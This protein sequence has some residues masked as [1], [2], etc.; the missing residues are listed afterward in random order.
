MRTNTIT[1]SLI[2]LFIAMQLSANTRF[3]LGGSSTEC[4][5]S[6]VINGLLTIDQTVWVANGKLL[7]KTN[8]LGESWIR[9]NR[10]DVRNLE[11]G[12]IP[13]LKARNGE[14]W[15]SVVFDTTFAGDDILAGGG[16][17]YTDDWGETW[18]YIP[19]P[20]DSDDET[21]YEPVK[22]PVQNTTWDLALTD[23][24]V[25]IASWGGGIRRSLDKGETWEVITA[26]GQPLSPTTNFTHMGFA[27]MFDEEAVWAG[28][29]SGIYRTTDGGR[30]WTNYNHRDEGISGN[31]VRALDVQFI[32][33]KK[34]I[35]ASTAETDGSD[36]TEFRGIAK[37]EDN[38]D[39]WIV[40]LE[41]EFAHE[42]GFEDNGAV[43]V[44]TD[45]GMFKSLDLGETWAVFPLIKDAET[46]EAMYTTEM[47]DMTQ[48]PQNSIW[49]GSSDGLARSFN[50]GMTWN[51]FRAYVPAGLE[52]EPLTYAYPNPFSPTRDNMFGGE[53]YVR[54]QYYL[55]EPSEVS[56]KIYD[57]GMN[58]VRAVVEHKMRSNAGDYAEVWNGRNGVGDIV[59]NGVYFYKLEIQGKNPVWGKIMVVN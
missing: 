44:A 39:T 6:N 21:R 34:I 5:S 2:L 38:G 41:G 43:Y 55:S 54:M 50:N 35:W 18:H 33:G 58:L 30:T 19:Q 10:S 57:F 56:I 27:V 29:G 45:N 49:L 51:I 52:N 4:L 9:Y 47:S 24:S 37:S 7:F 36:P 12:G 22:T 15:F 8:D 53:G 48:G 40:M 23:S 11:K 20:V 14:I 59:A 42:F 26:D 1:I 16:L 13:V 32:D 31:W 25:W 28:T 46:G 3:R 17:S